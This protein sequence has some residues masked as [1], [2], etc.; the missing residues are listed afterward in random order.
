MATTSTLTEAA[1]AIPL[2]ERTQQR[3]TR[4]SSLSPPDISQTPHTR[5]S[6]GIYLKLISVGF[7]FFVAGV[8]D[9]SIGALL[10]YVINEYNINT[11][12]VSSVY[13]KFPLHH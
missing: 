9:G 3:G 13:V 4:S 1:E 7:S 8:G 10:P 5:F 11:A 6:K 12:I 2:P